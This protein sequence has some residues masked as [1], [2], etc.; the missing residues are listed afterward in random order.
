MGITANMRRRQGGAII[1]IFLVSLFLILGMFGLALDAARLYNRKVDLQALADVAA[2]SAARKLVGTSLGVDQAV[3]A[4]AAAASR[5]NVNYGQD[6]VPWS[7]AAI[8]F[9]DSPSGGWRDASAARATPG[10]ILF[11]KVDTADLPASVGQFHTV[12]MRFLPDGAKIAATTA[13]AVAGRT[14]LNILPLGVCAMAPLVAEPRLVTGELVQ[15]GFRRGV[16]YDLMQL[17]PMPG[18]SEPVHFTIS[19]F[20]AAAGTSTATVGP[21]VCG[22]HLP[23]QSVVS[24]TVKVDQPFK[25]AELH[26]HLN[27]RF[28]QYP[29]GACDPRAAPPDKN[30]KSF[31]HSETNLW[32]RTTPTRQG[33][34][35]STARSRIETIADLPSPGNV[36]AELGMLWAAA[37][38]VP[39][40][41]YVPGMPEPENGYVAYGRGNWR[42]LYLPAAP[43][44]KPG[45]PDD[46]PYGARYSPYYVLPPLVHG[47]AVANRRILNVPLLS[48][49]VSG[50]SATVLGIGRFFM[51]VPAT[52]TSL[53]AEFG[54]LASESNLRGPVELYK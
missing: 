42:N 6:G 8:Q 20:G 28:G 14:T 11:V 43:E 27:S 29:T 26:E 48:C 52:P 54:G 30:I 2:L 34:A 38:P 10:K 49:P 7:E 15:Y 22:G 39:F 3:S 17:N 16:T 33:A 53:H 18:E 24:D 23:A 35:R 31:V 19:P 9:S 47:T 50:G 32:M 41:Q 4:A 25:L 45:Y 40:T 51:T 13:K 36:P 5:Q 46:T 1:V 12:F 44:P 21:Y 37:K